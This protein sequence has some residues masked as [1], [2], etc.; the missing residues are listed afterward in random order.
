VHES[1]VIAWARGA[2]EPRRVWNA[3]I[4]LRKMR[5]D[6]EVGEWIRT[7]ST[8]TPDSIERGYLSRAES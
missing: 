6:A 1:T 5:Y 4:A 7:G 3:P 8:R 2:F